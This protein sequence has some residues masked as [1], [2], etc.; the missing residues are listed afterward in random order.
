MELMKFLM[1]AKKAQKF[2]AISTSR[3]NGHL[4]IKFSK[5]MLGKPEM[6]EM[7][8]GRDVLFLII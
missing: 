5:S 3:I 1:F 4:E 6:I 2:F 7:M 8:C